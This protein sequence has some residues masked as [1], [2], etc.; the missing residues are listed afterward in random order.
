MLRDGAADFAKSDARG[1][2]LAR[3][4]LEHDRESRDPQPRADTAREAEIA[5]A[6][7]GERSLAVAAIHS[8]I[9]H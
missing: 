5:Q 3:L 7:P 1:A 6:L 9:Q 4:V 8:L 2:L